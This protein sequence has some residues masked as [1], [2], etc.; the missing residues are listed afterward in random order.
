MGIAPASTA[1]AIAVL[2]LQRGGQFLRFGKFTPLHRPRFD[3]YLCPFPESPVRGRADCLNVMPLYG[4][5]PVTRWI[6]CQGW[7]NASPGWH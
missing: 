6:G 3:A 4:C 5:H 1:V 7:H 2:V